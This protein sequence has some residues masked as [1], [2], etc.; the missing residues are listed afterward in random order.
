MYNNI[1]II[2]SFLTFAYVFVEEANIRRPIIKSVK[3][4]KGINYQPCKKL[5]QESF[6]FHVTI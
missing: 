6:F 2:R 3:K 4:K 1:S 5:D